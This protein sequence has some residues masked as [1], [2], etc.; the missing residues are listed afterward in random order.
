MYIFKQLSYMDIINYPHL[1]VFWWHHCH[2]S[3]AGSAH[4]LRC[5]YNI[6]TFH[7]STDQT[8]WVWNSSPFRPALP[9]TFHTLSIEADKASWN[10]WREG[11][12]NN[13]N[14]SLFR[15]LN[16]F[17]LTWNLSK[18]VHNKTIEE[19]K[20]SMGSLRFKQC[21]KLCWNLKIMEN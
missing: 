7:T 16:K 12:N 5:M 13:N 11:I 15:T 9:Q 4:S 17:T 10:L 19:L 21:V 3:I 6:T 14:N 18:R 1:R 20:K 2:R 8:S